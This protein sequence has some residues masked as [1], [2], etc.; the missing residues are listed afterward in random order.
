MPKELDLPLLAGG[1]C[2]STQPSTASVDAHHSYTLTREWSRSFHLTRM[3]TLLLNH[4]PPHYHHHYCHPSYALMS[5]AP[6]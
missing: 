4:H 6:I 2:H 3:S 1:A 5:K